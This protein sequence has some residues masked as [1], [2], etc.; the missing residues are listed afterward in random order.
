MERT[1]LLIL[2]IIR[3]GTIGNS[4]GNFGHLWIKTTIPDMRN[5]RDCI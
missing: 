1:C 4:F 5:L 3:K 2:F